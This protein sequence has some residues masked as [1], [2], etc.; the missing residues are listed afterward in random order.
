M[1]RIDF[2]K[3][4]TRKETVWDK[5]EKQWTSNHDTIEEPI[6]LAIDEIKNWPHKKVDVVNI[7]YINEN[8]AALHL[9]LRDK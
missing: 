7:V 2:V 3:I 6:N 1:T 4:V 8:K 9:R 5:K